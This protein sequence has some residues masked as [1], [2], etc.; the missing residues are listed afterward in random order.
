MR[1]IIQVLVLCIGLFCSS[2]SKAQQDVVS[3]NIYIQ[4]CIDKTQCSSINSAG[5]L[6]YDE[7]K[8]HIY[9]KV[10]FNKFKTGEDSVDYWLKDLTETY[11]MVKGP[12]AS[13]SFLGLSNNNHKTHRL[14]A[15]VFI[16]GIWQTQNIDVT[17]FSAE[18]SILAHNAF[19]TNYNKYKLNFSI[20]IV[21]KD[22][23]IH[24]K[25]QHLKKTIF[26]GVALGRVN[27]LTPSLQSQLGEAYSH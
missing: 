26:L 20:N 24:K 9:L 25:S 22:F 27:L 18:N 4:T 5:Y 15:Q 7:S 3:S 17:I 14:A 10:D 16:N 23:K 19:G 8:Q 6:F 12:L 21:P 2:K 1:K 11:L 13:E